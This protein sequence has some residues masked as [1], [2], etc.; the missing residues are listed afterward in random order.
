MPKIR[1]RS[2]SKA[3]TAGPVVNQSL[4]MTAATASMSDS[5]MD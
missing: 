5:S 1:A 4:R 3:V 2:P